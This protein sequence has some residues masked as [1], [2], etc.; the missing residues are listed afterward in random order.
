MNQA[1]SGV[2]FRSFFDLTSERIDSQGVRPPDPIIE[3]PPALK[4]G[5][6]QNR[7]T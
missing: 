2:R 1:R 6:R 3:L 7:S 5:N 4:T